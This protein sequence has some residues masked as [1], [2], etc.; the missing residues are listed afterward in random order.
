[1]NVR[2]DAKDDVEKA[3]LVRMILSHESFRFN[4]S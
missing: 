4:G 2:M 1:M 3:R